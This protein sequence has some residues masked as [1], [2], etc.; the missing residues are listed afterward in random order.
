MTSKHEDHDH[1]HHHRRKIG[2]GVV[3]IGLA[4]SAVA[5]GVA[6][7]AEIKSNNA[8]D[9]LEN[10][11]LPSVGASGLQGESGPS[12]TQGPSGEQGLS[13][14]SGN[15]GVSGQQGT[16]GDSFPIDNS[17]FGIGVASPVDSTQIPVSLVLAN[18]ASYVLPLSVGTG[19]SLVNFCI[20]GTLTSGDNLGMDVFFDLY[21]LPSSTTTLANRRAWSYAPPNV[22]AQNATIS[23]ITL[24]TTT[25]VLITATGTKAGTLFMQSYCFSAVRVTPT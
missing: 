25:A 18:V 14:P 16:P 11:I 24:N 7:D 21:E 15:I 8:L 13:G 9:Q 3:V 17:A 1:H 10:L 12:G 20:T 6:I 4:A 2:A 19:K 23:W 5:L 22:V